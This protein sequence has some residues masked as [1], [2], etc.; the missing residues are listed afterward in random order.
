MEFIKVTH[1]LFKFT[2]GDEK[3]EGRVPRGQLQA[4]CFSI[5]ERIAA[6]ERADHPSEPHFHKSCLSVWISGAIITERGRSGVDKKRVGL[7]LA[8]FIDDRSARDER[9]F[10]AP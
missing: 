4:C 6:A 5:S 10:V 7:D 1:G 9:N 8:R 2:T 3:L